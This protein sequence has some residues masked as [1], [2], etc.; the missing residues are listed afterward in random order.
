MKMIHFFWLIN[1]FLSISILSG[2]WWAAIALAVINI[3]GVILQMV[4]HLLI[5]AA[6]GS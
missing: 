5:K 4:A 1:L 3:I 2:A 6:G